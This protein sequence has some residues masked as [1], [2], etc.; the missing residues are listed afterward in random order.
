MSWRAHLC[1]GWLQTR[2]KAFWAWTLKSCR[3]PDGLSTAQHRVLLHSPFP[4]LLGQRRCVPMQLSNSCQDAMSS[5]SPAI[6][7]LSV[8]PIPR[9]WWS[10]FL[11]FSPS[12]RRRLLPCALLFAISAL[13]VPFCNAFFGCG[14]FKSRCWVAAHQKGWFCSLQQH[15]P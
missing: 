7:P 10:L 4:L 6:A 13:L 14:T 1:Q 12:R 11:H 9:A 5:C 8:C 15:A 2:T 3:V